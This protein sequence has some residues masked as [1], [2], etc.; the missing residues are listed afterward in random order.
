M[1]FGQCRKE[2]DYERWLVE[3]LEWM[4]EQ[5]DRFGKKNTS[6]L[7]SC[8]IVV[9]Q[10]V[11]FRSSQILG[12]NC[13]FKLWMPISRRLT[14]TL[15]GWHNAEIFSL[16]LCNCSKLCVPVHDCWVGWEPSRL[17]LVLS[18]SV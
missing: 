12:C 6:G 10:D 4:S 16:L 17:L 15:I 7:L 9:L 14:K 1:Q 5:A 8:V 18:L 3:L 11:V 13:N 2:V